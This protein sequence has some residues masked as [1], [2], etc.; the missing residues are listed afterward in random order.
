MKAITDSDSI[1]DHTG[2]IEDALSFVDVPGPGMIRIRNFIMENSFDEKP[3]D[4]KVSPVSSPVKAVIS[5]LVEA[6][7]EFRAT[8]AMVNDRE[9]KF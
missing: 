4:Q 5:W 8:Q 9:N 1:F 6:T 7:R 3:E 2:C